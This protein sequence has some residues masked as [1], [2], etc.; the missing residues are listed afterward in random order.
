MAIGETE[1]SGLEQRAAAA[2][3]IVAAN[4][5]QMARLAEME[6]L[7]EEHIRSIRPPKTALAYAQDW[8]E[9]ETYCA[10]LGVP[11]LPATK[12]QLVGYAR[13]L[14][15]KGAAPA[16]VQRRLT[17]LAVT[18][19]DMGH[20][21][22]QDGRKAFLATL[23]ADVKDMQIRG[24]QR[25]RGKS[26]PVLLPVLH[27]MLAVCPTDTL[28]GLRT[29]FLLLAGFGVAGRREELSALRAFDITIV[30]D[31]GMEVDI[32]V[33]K[34]EPRLVKVAAGENPATCPIRAWQAWQAK[35]ELPADGYALRQ[36]DRHGNVGGGLSPHG[37]G[38]IITRCTQAAKID[39]VTAHGLRS[40]FATVARMAGKDLLTISRTGGWSPSSPTLYGYTRVVDEW[41]DNATQGI[42]L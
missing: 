32:R 27:R 24:E 12:G 8:A 25:G 29:R 23:R 17:G 13:W 10:E 37:V 35:A 4:A 33:S 39:A 3:A 21:L 38:R 20:P 42:G 5:E 34:S 2:R 40:G 9:W 1:M 22:E 18:A 11:E 16:T 6:E 26:A 14:W 36:V 28:A 15:L 19:R 30:P 41:N 31:L 7:A